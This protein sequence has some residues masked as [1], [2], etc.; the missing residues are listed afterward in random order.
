MG[1]IYMFSDDKTT[2]LIVMLNQLTTLDKIKW[3]ISDAP[4]T[5][6]KATD[7]YIPL[8]FS[9]NYQ[10]QKFAIYEC[11]YKDYNPELDNFYW[12][13]MLILAVLDLQGRVLWQTN[14]YSSALKDLFETIRNKASNIDT[15]IDSL[16]KELKTLNNS[17]ITG[18]DD[19]LF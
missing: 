3:S 13:E 18:L 9:A 8:Y 2:N 16:T 6:T 11:R 17:N 7:D 12:T 1:V 19:M 14:K 4:A 5:L 15:L 10:N